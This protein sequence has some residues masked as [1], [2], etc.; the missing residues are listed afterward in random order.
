STESGV[1]RGSSLTTGAAGAIAAASRTREAVDD[2]PSVS[3]RSATLRSV[4]HCCVQLPVA[5][6]YLTRVE[7]S[8]TARRWWPLAARVEARPTRLIEAT[9]DAPTAVA[10]AMASS[11]SATAAGS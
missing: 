4:V 2:R 6:Q 9:N 3:S 7:Y 1:G 8:C 10:R 11:Y 5:R